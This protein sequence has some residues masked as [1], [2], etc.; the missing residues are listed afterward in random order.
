MTML[1]TLWWT[2]ESEVIFLKARYSLKTVLHNLTLT[3]CYKVH[4]GLNSFLEHSFGS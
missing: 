3:S 2:N 4:S 1:D